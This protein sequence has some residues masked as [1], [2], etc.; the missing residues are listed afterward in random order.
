ML[1]PITDLSGEALGF[2]ASDKL[3]AKDF[4]EVLIPAVEK[5]LESHEKINLLMN[6]DHDFQSIEAGA[7]WDDLKFGFGHWRCWNKVAVV[8]DK[9]WLKNTMKA[10]GTVFPAQTETYLEDQLDLAKKWIS[11]A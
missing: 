9:P 2:T 6:F 5:Q 1:T 8:T 3:T 10:V 7:V 4:E 11:E